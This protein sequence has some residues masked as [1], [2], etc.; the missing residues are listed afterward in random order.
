METRIKSRKF[1]RDGLEQEIVGSIRIKTTPEGHIAEIYKTSDGKKNFFVTLAGSHWCSHGSSL[2]DAIG[3][4]LWKDPAQ[5]PSMDALRDSVKGNKKHKFTLNEFRLLTG[6]CLTGCRGALE[7]VRRDE[8]PMTAFDIRDI[9]SR[10]WGNKLIS[11]LGWE[12]VR[13]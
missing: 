3:S 8:S 13:S 11:V 9:I 4:A 1:F 10:E 12:K 7:K 5:R 6:A 2:A